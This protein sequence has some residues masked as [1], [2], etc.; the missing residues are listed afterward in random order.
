MLSDCCGELDSVGSA[1]LGSGS[2]EQP[3]S[4][5]TA[6][7]A[8]VAKRRAAGITIRSFPSGLGIYLRR[9]VG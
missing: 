7:V 5:T 1:N 3:T 2:S 4:V 9:R 6:S 8:T